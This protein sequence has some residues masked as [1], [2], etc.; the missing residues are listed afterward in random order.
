[1]GRKH[2]VGSQGNHGVCTD[3]RLNQHGV[4]GRLLRSRSQ[5]ARSQ[6]REGFA[7]KGQGFIL[8]PAKGLGDG[9]LFATLL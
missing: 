2:R 3:P 4:E 9:P 8:P 1:M 7:S 6:A 5:R